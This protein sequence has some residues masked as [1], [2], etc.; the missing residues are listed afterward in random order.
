MSGPIALR[1]IRTESWIRKVPAPIRSRILKPGPVPDV[2]VKLL[3]P[4]FYDLKRYVL[5]GAAVSSNP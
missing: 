4:L 1:I 3:M 2:Q 5:Q